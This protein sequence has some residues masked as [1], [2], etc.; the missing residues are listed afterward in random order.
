MK[1]QLFLSE[2]KWKII[3][4]YH[5]N[6]WPGS[7]WISRAS[8][9][10]LFEHDGRECAHDACHLLRKWVFC[11]RFQFTSDHKPKNV[12]TKLWLVFITS[13]FIDGARTCAMCDSMK[14]RCAML[15]LIMALISCFCFSLLWYRRL[16]KRCDTSSTKQNEN[17]KLK[18]PKH[19]NSTR[20]R[21][22]IDFKI[23]HILHNFMTISCTSLQMI[24]FTLSAKRIEYII[25]NNNMWTTVARNFDFKWDQKDGT[26]ST[27]NCIA[28]WRR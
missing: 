21:I 7:R 2:W 14:V 27:F 12:P 23:V 3:V 18:P 20:R 6:L 13:I 15:L 24:R 17:K 8:N 10:I 9:S 4:K 26:N 5:L 25:L 11:Q 1:M 28:Y 22:N 19:N 16:D